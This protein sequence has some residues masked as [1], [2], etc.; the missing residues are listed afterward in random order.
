MNT[1]I[2]LLVSLAAV[3]FTA[4]AN[5]QNCTNGNNIFHRKAGGI[6]I[7]CSQS[8]C[9]GSDPKSNMNHIVSGGSIGGGTQPQGIETALDTVSDMS[10]LRSGLGLTTSDIADISLYIWYRAGNSSCP[11][12]TPTVGASPGSLAFGSVT[13]GSSSSPQ[14]VTFTNTGG[15]SATG[16]TIGAVPTGY[17]R[18]TTCTATLAAGGSCTVTVTFSPTAAQAYGGSM[19]ITGSGGTSITVSLSGTGGAAAGPNVNTSATS[20]SFGS[21]TVGQT[22]T[23][24][25]ITVSNSGTA[26][27]TNMSYPPAPAKFNKSGTCASATLNAGASC[28]I[29]FTYSPT[30][31]G[32]DNTTYTFTGGGKTFPIALSGAGATTAP[33]VNV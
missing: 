17:S 1:P 4:V 12:A 6:D 24:Q 26:A 32:S 14:V 27:A 11:A 5:A 33:P 16:F 30:A 25:T 18:A 20:L 3:A 15:A 10:G 13:V 9:H 29:V 21:I 8:S 2:R 7:S 23:A 31:V 28:T 22:S 19:L